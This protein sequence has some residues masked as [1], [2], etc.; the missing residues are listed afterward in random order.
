VCVLV[1]RRWATSYNRDDV[2]D[3]LPE[4]EREDYAAVEPDELA[5]RLD[6]FWQRA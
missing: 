3:Y 6:R 5:D 1:D 4:Y 2:R